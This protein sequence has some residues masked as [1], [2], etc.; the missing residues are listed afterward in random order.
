MHVCVYIYICVY[1]C[2]CVCVCVYIYIYIY[3]FFY[4]PVP[5]RIVHIYLLLQDLSCLLSEVS[6][7]WPCYLVPN[8]LPKL[9]KPGVEPQLH[10]CPDLK[11]VVPPSFGLRLSIML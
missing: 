11:D 6:G 2:V 7:H 10:W 8:T 4:P 9:L 5:S 1:V 3:I